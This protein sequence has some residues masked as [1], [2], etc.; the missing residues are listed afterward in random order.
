MFEINDFITKWDGTFGGNQANEGTYFY[1]YTITG[2]DGTT[3]SGHQF[4]ELL[5]K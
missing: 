2:L 1:K 3:Q 5:R 4:V